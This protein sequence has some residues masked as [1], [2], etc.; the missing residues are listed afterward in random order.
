MCTND[1]VVGLGQQISYI[2]ERIVWFCIHHE[3]QH[4]GI[5]EIKH[6]PAEHC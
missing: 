2:R 5:I 1:T 6:Y 4:L 3:I